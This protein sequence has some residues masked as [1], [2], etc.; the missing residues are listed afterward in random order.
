MSK[1]RV[2]IV[3]SKFAADLH[4][5]AYSRNRAV[6]IAAIAA[7]D[8]LEVI[9]RKWG[10]PRTYEDYHEMFRKEQPDLVSVCVPNFLHHDVVIA[11]SMVGLNA[12]V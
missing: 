6:E 7:L 4:C 9:A 11:A 1:V 8:N 10:V 2:C 5:D 3:G 12:L